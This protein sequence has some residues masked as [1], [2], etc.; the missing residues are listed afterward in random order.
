[1]KKQ[2]WMIGSALLL[3]VLMVAGGTMA[4]FTATADPVVNEFKAGTVGIKVHEQFDKKAAQNVNPGDCYEKVIYIENTGTKKAYVRIKADA[5][6]TAVNGDILSNGVLNYGIAGPGVQI[7]PPKLLP[8]WTLKGDYFYYDRIVHP[9]HFT[10]P[11]L[12]CNR[13]C[14][15][16]PKM[17]NEYQGASL[18]ITIN[19]D[20]IQATHGAAKAEWGV[21]YPTIKPYSKGEEPV[22]EMLTEADVLAIVAAE[23]AEFEALNLE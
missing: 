13:V 12:K 18:D 14:F 19:A 22:E 15:D 6:F 2:K 8:G 4:W 21:N 10:K 9:N 16:G 1:M 17:G 5:V 7:W 23:N 20:A 3:A 11:L